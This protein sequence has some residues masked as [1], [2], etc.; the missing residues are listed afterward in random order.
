M[1][2]SSAVVF[3]DVETTGLNHW[4]HEIWEIAVIDRKVVKHSNQPDQNV[5]SEHVFHIRPDLTRADPTAL[6]IGRFYERTS[7]LDLPP[8]RSGSI[9]Q[10]RVT[11]D[12]ESLAPS[13]LGFV[14]RPGPRWQDPT[15]VARTLARLLDGKHIVGAVPGFDANF[16]QR[17]L[18]KHGQA[19]TWHYHLIDVEALA[20]G[21]LACGGSAPALPWSSDDLTEALGVK[22]DPAARHTAVGDARWARDMYDA[23][24]RSSV[25]MPQLAPA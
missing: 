22:V 3:V 21:F 13:A 9:H 17:F 7:D 2:A 19:A 10:I 20:M 5:D 4:H 12:G 15:P 11:L 24:M 25:S 16:L 6:R 8:E 23:V 14:P 1:T 18:F